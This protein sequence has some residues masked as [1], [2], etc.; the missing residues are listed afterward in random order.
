M[1]KEELKIAKEDLVLWL[2]RPPSNDDLD[3]C[4]YLEKA[5]ENQHNYY[6]EIKQLKIEIS[7]REEVCNR[8]ESNWNKLK[9]YI[10][11][12]NK[13]LCWTNNYDDILNEI[14]KL[15]RSD[16]NGKDN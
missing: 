1:D 5:L 8:L 10:V 12:N 9:E 15:E 2:D 4:A 6:Q 11:E 3:L 7:A 16:S 14:Q 13:A